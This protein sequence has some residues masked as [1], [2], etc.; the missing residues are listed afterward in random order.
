MRCNFIQMKI[1]KKEETTP[2]IWTDET[3]LIKKSNKMES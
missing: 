2:P 1:R 3:V